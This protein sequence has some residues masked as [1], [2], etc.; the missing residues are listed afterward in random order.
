MQLGK[1]LKSNQAVE[2]GRHRVKNHGR[3]D[4]LLSTCVPGG[5]NEGIAWKGD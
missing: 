4:S 1:V 2:D 3:P 5:E